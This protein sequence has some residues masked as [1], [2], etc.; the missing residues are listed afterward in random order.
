MSQ[1]KLVDVDGMSAH[2]L[3]LPDTDEEQLIFPAGI[4]V[5]RVDAKG[6]HIDTSGGTVPA[7]EL[8][9]VAALLQRYGGGRYEVYARDSRGRVMMRRMIGPLPGR[10]KPMA[11]IDGLDIELEEEKAPP[12]PPAPVVQPLGEIAML[13]QGQREFMAAMLASQKEET[14]ATIERMEKAHAATMASQEKSSERMF[15]MMLEVM[16]AKTEAPIVQAKELAPANPLEVFMQGVEYAN[17]LRE[18]QPTNN[19]DIGDT[20]KLFAAGM[21][22]MQG[23]KKASDGGTP[24]AG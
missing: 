1:P 3:F 23:G 12:P 16:K 6:R 21:E 18:T 2:E 5:I 13:M 4:S 15:G 14:R 10:P 7:H 8:P 17:A 11:D 19:D 20:I 24:P 9:N 22:A